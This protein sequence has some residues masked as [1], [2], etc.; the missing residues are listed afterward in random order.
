MRDKKRDTLLQRYRKT[1]YKSCS[2]FT[3]TLMDG[4]MNF[5]HHIPALD[6]LKTQN[7]LGWTEALLNLSK[8]CNWSDFELLEI[9]KRAINP[10]YWPGLE[11]C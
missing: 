1:D 10:Q 5:T 4:R 8:I 2:T 6:D 11:N 3:S 7:L 9:S